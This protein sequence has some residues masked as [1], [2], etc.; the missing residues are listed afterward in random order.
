MRDQFEF[1]GL[2]SPQRRLAVKS[3]L[4]TL[5]TPSAPDVLD[6]AEQLWALPER[7]LTYAACDVL[8]RYVRLLPPEAFDGPLRTLVTTRPW[9]D[10]VDSLAGGTLRPMLVRYPPLV[11]V[12]EDWSRSA[13]RWLVRV[14]VTSQLGRKDGTD[15]DRLFALCALHGSDHEFFVAKAVG[16]ALRDY[17]YTDPAAVAA[18]VA[19]HPDLAPVA[20]REALKHIG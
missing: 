13:D 5:R 18:F 1:L 17:A 20:R 10:S 11:G 3:V 2:T 6:C 4:R 19:A 14:A 15:A 9:W 16:W 7:E 8:A 12:V